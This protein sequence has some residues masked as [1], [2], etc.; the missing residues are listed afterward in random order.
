MPSWSEDLKVPE[1]SNKSL[2]MMGD[3]GRSLVSAVG[4]PTPTKLRQLLSHLELMIYPNFP[5]SHQSCGILWANAASISSTFASSSVRRICRNARC[6]DGV[7]LAETMHHLSSCNRR[8]GA[9]SRTQR[10]ECSGTSSALT[11]SPQTQHLIR[12][13][14]SISSAVKAPPSSPMEIWWSIPN[15]LGL[16]GQLE[17]DMALAIAHP[18]LEHFSCVRL[19][20]VAFKDWNKYKTPINHVYDMIW[21]QWSLFSKT[22]VRNSTMS[23]CLRKT[24]CPSCNAPV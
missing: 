23:P 21:C 24:T 9:G 6:S 13:Y 20:E 10:L 3:G 17:G 19:E 2:L 22:C 16:S 5:G 15:H 11:R 7:I 1:I 18:S 8:F 4:F 12:L 14:S